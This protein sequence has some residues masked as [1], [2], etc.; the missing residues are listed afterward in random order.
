MPRAKRRHTNVDSQTVM[1]EHRCGGIWGA[2][3]EI[4]GGKD[5]IKR[6]GV[7]TPHLARQKPQMPVFAS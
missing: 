6:S 2:G 3:S 1:G 4:R 7:R 5:A